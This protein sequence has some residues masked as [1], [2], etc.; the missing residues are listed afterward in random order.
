MRVL[1]ACEESQS[2]CIAFRERG[3]EA[4]SCDIIDCSGGHPEWHI[5]DDVLNHLND[6]YDLMIAFP[7]CT[8]LAMSGAKHF[9]KKRSDGRQQKSIDFFLRFTKTNIPRWAIEN[10]IGIMSTAYRK[11]DIIVNPYDF[12][13]PAQKPTCFWLHG[14]P[15]LKATEMD[16]PLF[17]MS[18]NKGDFHTT[19]SGKVL[20][21][22]YNLPPSENRAKLRSKT[23]PGIARAMAEQWG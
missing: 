15:K 20:P 1:I 17:G 11:P 10:P 8:D 3:H 6:G 5:K 14:L 12:G 19:K 23:F 7:P 13:D 22:W 18:L 21:K 2:V 16:A 9:E 4:Y